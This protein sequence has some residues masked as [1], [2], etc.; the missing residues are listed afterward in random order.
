MTKPLENQ[1]KT[2]DQYLDEV[3]YSDNDSY[4]PSPFA[5]EFIN[6]IK[7]VNGSEGEENKTP[8]LHLRMLDTVASGSNRIVNLCHRG[9]G[10]T[11]IMAEYLFL[12]IAVFGELPTIGR[13]DL[14]MYVSDSMENGAKNLRKNVEHRWENS[15]FLKRYVP[16][17][18]FTDSRIEF[19]NRAGKKFVVKLYGAKTGVR[20]VKE[21]GKRPTLCVADDII[22]DEDARSPTILASI[23]DTMY[24]AVTYAL[25][26]KN[27]MI[28]W[29]GTPFNQMDS[30]YKA[31]ESGA[32][33]A[34]VYPVCEQFPVEPHDFVGSWPDR[35]PYEYVKQQYQMAKSNGMIDSFYQELMLRITSDEE[36]LIRDVD[37]KWYSGS[38]IEPNI[39]NYNFYITTDFATSE[40]S[41]ADYSVISLW[42]YNNNEEWMLHSGYMAKSLM[43]VNIDRLFEFVIRYDVKQV[44]V[45]VTGQQKAF[46]TWINK[47]MHKRNC[48]FT[49]VEVRPTADKMRR[50]HN[51][52][53]LFRKGR[54]WFNKDMVGTKFMTEALNE[55][56]R[57]TMSQ[58]ASRHDD[59][60]DTVSSLPELRPW[61]PS[62]YNMESKHVIPSPFADEIEVEDPVA[63]ESYIV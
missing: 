32:W 20:G 36:R 16:E 3:D 50:L 14:A 2:V 15:E 28:I 52:V 29:S 27:S 24:K 61:K 44:S 45:E 21:M 9:S 57:A 59:F 34:N 35:F 33:D 55:I 60:L 51:V 23:E 26:P 17:T 5:I 4:V 22:S 54:I 39:S 6:F 38:D 56:S 1:P 31:V 42:A 53:P 47:E 19:K 7:L 40:K 8:V 58:I 49:I 62:A 11:T 63:Y 10:K 48:Y 46:V 30:I 25:H 12:Y 43:D 41:S 18:R 13:V 37:I